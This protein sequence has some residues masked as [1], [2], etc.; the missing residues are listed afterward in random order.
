VIS[1]DHELC[2][3]DFQ[4]HYRLSVVHL[5]DPD[6][7][8]EQPH[9]PKGWGP[10]LMLVGPDGKV[11]FQRTS[12]VDREQKLISLIKEAKATHP[13]ISPKLV[14]GI[15][16]MP[17]TLER[18]G[19][20][21]EP[22]PCE[23][24]SSLAAGPDGKVYLA[25]TASRA[26]NS[27]IVMRTWDGQA[28][29]DDIPVAATEADEYDGTVIVGKNNDVWICWTSNAQDSMYNIFV[30]N[31]Q[32]VL[33]GTQP[34]RVTDA[35][36]DAMHGR[37]ACDT[38]GRPWITYYQW[39]KNRTGISRDREIYA[40]R[41]DGTRLSQAIQISP[42]DVSI[43]ED[44]TDPGIIRM[45]KDM[46]VC[47]SWDYHQPKGYTTKAL[48]PSIF[49][50]TINTELIPTSRAFHLSQRQIDMVPMLGYGAQEGA[51]C[52]WDSLVGGPNSKSLCVR[53][54]TA[55]TAIGETLTI[56]KGLRHLCS[57]CFA[58]SG[59]QDGVLVWCQTRDGQDWSLERSVLNPKN[60]QWSQPHT[61]A[62]EGNP[63]YSSAVYDTKG[64]LWVAYSR[65]TPRGRRVI[66]RQIS[67]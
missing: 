21:K 33:T 17:G 9:N 24:F 56:S 7:S 58:F 52:A 51:W 30:T 19:E 23:R 15:A 67:L 10:F 60:K 57:P 13:A 54:L 53:S 4:K 36:D 62:L 2:A 6:Q 66:C 61:L 14:D 22:R 12:L 29:S 46:M 50:R 48:S 20:A 34:T 35:A 44:H 18:S 3:L 45:G 31:L 40:R 28:W 47:W 27:D 59:E 42:T 5:M 16:Y 11:K 65:E 38:R 49:A 63:R 55:N 43:Y 32:S 26:N 64:Q 25:L 8:F 1:G 39:H 41:L 37:M